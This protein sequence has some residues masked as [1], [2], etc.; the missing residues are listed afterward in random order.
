MVYYLFIATRL[1]RYTNYSADQVG[2]RIP[3]KSGVLFTTALILTDLGQVAIAAAVFVRLK[4]TRRHEN[5]EIFT[6]T[7]AMSPANGAG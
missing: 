3:L 4:E 2:K 5:H 7:R 6:F 1:E